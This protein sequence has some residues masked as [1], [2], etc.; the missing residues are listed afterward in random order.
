MTLEDVVRRSACCELIS[1]FDGEEGRHGLRRH[2]GR[3][4][5]ES[6]AG[7]IL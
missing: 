3:R 5:R 7:S 2:G 1:K 4:P 6:F